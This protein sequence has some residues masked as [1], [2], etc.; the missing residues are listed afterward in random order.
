M[1]DEF[2]HIALRATES[3]HNVGDT[4]PNSFRWNDG[5]CLEDEQLNGACGLKITSEEELNAVISEFRADYAWGGRV[6]YVIGGNVAEYG[7]D[8]GEIIIRKAKVIKVMG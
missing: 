1:F 4:M 7:E 6:V 5:E 3:G 8:A 2:D